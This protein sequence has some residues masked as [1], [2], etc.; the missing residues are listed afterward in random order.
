M[1]DLVLEFPESLRAVVAREASRRGVSESAWIE[2]AVR[3]K[4]AAEAEMAYLAGRGAGAN[5]AAYDGALDRVPAAPPEPG[6]ER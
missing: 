6:D 5:R 4:L 3:E 1:S 2:E